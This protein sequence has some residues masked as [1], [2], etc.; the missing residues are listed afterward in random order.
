MSKDELNEV[1]EFHYKKIIRLCQ[2]YIDNELDYRTGVS[3]SRLIEI[4]K[5]IA[6]LS[7]ERERII[8]VINLMIEL[9]KGLIDND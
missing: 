2:K 4:N 9:D 3:D 5:V 8:E 6:N 1:K 7:S